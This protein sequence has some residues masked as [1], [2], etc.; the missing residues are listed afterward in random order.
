MICYKCRKEVE[1]AKVCPNCGADLKIFYKVK[2]LSNVYYNDALEK[3]NAR[4]LSG[5][6]V[7]L[8]N[9]LKFNKYNINAR[10]LLGLVYFELGEFVDALCEWVISKNYQSEDNLANKYLE[11][12]QENQGRLETI[13]HTIKKYNQGSGSWRFP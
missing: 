10:N 7:S 6:V 8:R 9:S 5:A 11:E 4:D 13:N 3:A 12:I 2:N 1:N